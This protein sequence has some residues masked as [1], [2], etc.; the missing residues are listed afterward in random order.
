MIYLKRVVLVL[1][2][3]IFIPLL[4]VFLLLSNIYRTT[5]NPD[6]YDTQLASVA[7]SNSA[8]LVFENLKS[9]VPE[10]EK[11]LPTVEFEDMFASAFPQDVVLQSWQFFIKDLRDMHF[12]FSEGFAGLDLDLAFAQEGFR[13]LAKQLASTV[14]KRLPVCLETKLEET[15]ES[16]PPVEN[17]PNCLKKDLSTDFYVEQKTK[18]VD[19]SFMRLIPA[20]FHILE[21][22][23]APDP[24]F[25]F[26][27][28]SFVR[29]M[30]ILGIAMLLFLL[31]LV[32]LSADSWKF[33]LIYLGSY[34][35]IL[36]ILVLVLRR[37]LM[38]VLPENIEKIASVDWREALLHIIEKSLQG[39]NLYIVI[40]FVLGLIMLATGIYCKRREH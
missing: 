38:S 17:D 11:Y 9:E 16:L 33:A 14:V 2:S 3:V 7:Y 18:E 19:N 26:N 1:L 12:K 29:F 27:E 36:G 32:G 34:A 35:V 40:F 8:K 20:S 28:F 30:M 22:E 5:L 13:D 10:V 39:L 4:L 31:M 21:L 37:I 15:D 24:G 25:L 23:P 6:F